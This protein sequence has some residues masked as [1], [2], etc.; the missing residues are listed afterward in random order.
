MFCLFRG[1]GPRFSSIWEVLGGSRGFRG[2]FFCKISSQNLISDT[3][4]D[5]AFTDGN[6]AS[7]ETIKYRSLNSLIK[8]NWTIINSEFWNDKADGKR[9]R[10]SEFLIYPKIEVKYISEFSVNNQ[11][12]KQEFENELLKKSSKIPVTIDNKCFFL[13]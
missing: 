9:I 3:K 2:I 1:A 12:L 11:K 7:L 8:L 6:A 13:S 10:N 4:I 5:F